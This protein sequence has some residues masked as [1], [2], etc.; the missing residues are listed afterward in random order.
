MSRYEITVSIGGGHELDRAGLSALIASLPGLCF[1]PLESSPPPQVLIWVARTDANDLPSVSHDTALLLL[2]EDAAFDSLPETVTGLLSKDEPPAALGIAIRQVARGEQYLSPSLAIGVLQKR[3]K[4]LS[5]TESQKSGIE[6]LTS[7]ER[8]ILDLLA[9]GLSNKAIAARL[10]L[11]VRTV[12]GHLANIYSR[13]EVHS[14]T[15]AM[16]L[17][18]RVG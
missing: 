9:Q 14:R 16:L 10:Y 4:K 1:V 13:L 5:L 7:R 15:E 17:A 2:T 18:V 6:S 8:E 12:E 3:R 11:S